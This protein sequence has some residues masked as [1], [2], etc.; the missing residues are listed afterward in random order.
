MDLPLKLSDAVLLSSHLLLAKK[1]DSTLTE[2]WKNERALNKDWGIPWS[3][4][5][6][7]VCTE[8]EVRP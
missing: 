7:L 4:V 6:R 5:S 2:L 3:Q 1:P 8:F